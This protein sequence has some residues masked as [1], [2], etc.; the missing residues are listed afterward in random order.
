VVFSLFG[1]K[2]PPKDTKPAKP[3]ARPARAEGKPPPPPDASVAP[4]EVGDLDFT[5][6]APASPQPA[7]PPS[8]SLPPSAMP[9]IAPESLAPESMAPPSLA[10]K[11]RAPSLPP[12]SMPPSIAKA[13]SAP[14]SPPAS[15]EREA[16]RRGVDSNLCI[17][18]ETGAKDIPT[19]IE[20]TA[21]LFANGQAKDALARINEAIAGDELDG[22]QL[23]AWLMLFDLYQHLGMR[24]AFEEKALEFVVKF[25][26]SP[27]AWADAPP[28][29]PTAAPKRPGGGAGHV[30]LSGALTA[31]SAPHF[32]QVKKLAEK[33]PKLRIDFGRLAG[34]DAGGAKLLL[35]TIAG[36][37]KAGKELSFVGD[38]TL[39]KLIGAVAKSGDRSVDPALWLLLLELHQHLGNQQAYEDAALEYAITYEVSPPAWENRGP[40]T[41]AN[42]AGMASDSGP[43]GDEAFVIDGEV[44]GPSDKLLADLEGYAAAANPVVIDML[45]ARR[46]D[47]VSAGQLLNVLARIKQAGKSIEI[48]G[49]N[50]MIVALFAMMGIREFARLVPRK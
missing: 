34:V 11:S 46:V 4:D 15:D 24:T 42:A 3:Q 12:L 2:P 5:N 30:A 17:E 40:A 1:K 23:Q 38:A 45:R 6:W 28:S 21:I 39:V 33:Q 27:P 44:A 36:I 43:V 10:P 13:Q 16:R 7:S 19:A 25:E 18:V 41:A 47:F 49:A 20:E 50:E 31:A 48:R 37:R 14:P 22:W 8:F 26:R 35:E 9:S 29:A 32:E